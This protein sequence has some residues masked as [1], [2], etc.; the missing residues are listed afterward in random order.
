MIL[1]SFQN[2]AHSAVCVTPVAAALN[3]YLV[4]TS[5]TTT[6]V[7]H[8]VIIAAFVIVMDVPIVSLGTTST[9]VTTHV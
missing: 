1:C 9:L 5:M 6:I 3:A 7:Q 8:A 4:S 2:V